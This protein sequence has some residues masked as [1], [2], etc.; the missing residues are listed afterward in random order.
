MYTFVHVYYSQ[1]YYMYYFIRYITHTQNNK[2]STIILDA[3]LYITMSL[4]TFRQFSIHA[5]NQIK[6]LKHY[7][8]DLHVYNIYVIILSYLQI[9]FNIFST[10]LSVLVYLYL[11]VGFLQVL[12]GTFFLI[13]SLRTLFKYIN[14][15]DMPE[16]VHLIWMIPVNNHSKYMSRPR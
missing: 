4:I 14:R 16:E 9:F 12:Y 6:Y 8:I 5:T 15:P 10:L 7:C 1:Y 11:H 3:Y 13:G 2:G